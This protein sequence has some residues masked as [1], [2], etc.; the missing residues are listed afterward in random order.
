MAAA[1]ALLRQ[2]CIHQVDIGFVWVLFVCLL[3]VCSVWFGVCSGDNKSKSF[4]GI[5]MHK[6]VL[7]WQGFNQHTT[8][9]IEPIHNRFI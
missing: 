9:A 7:I 5:C 4:L 3:F 8:G 6:K 1:K 2:S